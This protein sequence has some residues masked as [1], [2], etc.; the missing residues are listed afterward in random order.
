L[1]LSDLKLDNFK[2]NLNFFE[3]NLYLDIIF[4][5]P[6][7]SLSSKNYSYQM[8]IY[9][10]IFKEEDF[11]NQK[12]FNLIDFGSTSSL[13]FVSFSGEKLNFSFSLTKCP[14]SSN[15]Y[16]FA[17][18]L[19]DLLDQ[20]NFS[21]PVISSITFPEN[22][23]ESTGDISQSSKIYQRVL[24][25]EIRILEGT[26]TGEYLEIYN[27]NNFTVNLNGFRIERITKSGKNYTF[28]SKSNFS[29]IILPPFSYLLI[30]NS[31]TDLDIKNKADIIYPSSY[32]LAKNNALRIV[33]KDNNLIDEVCW[34]QV[35]GF[36]NCLNNPTSNNLS[37]Q[38]KKTAFSSF[39]NI[40]SEFLNKNGE[41][42]Y[43][44][45][46]YDTDISFFDFIQAELE[47]ENSKVTKPTLKEILPLDISLLED[48]KVI[49]KW[50]SPAFYEKDLFYLLKVSIANGFDNLNTSTLNFID[51]S[52]NI[53][54]PSFEILSFQ[55]VKFNLDFQT[56]NLDTNF[57]DRLLIFKLS[58][59]NK[60]NIPDEKFFILDS[61][62]QLNKF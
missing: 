3:D 27:P 44:G 51:L 14:T 39:E 22:F 49:L 16:F 20:E 46:A 26:S 13:P 41:K 61:N 36:S 62:W 34:G 37:F 40:K 9:S 25:S 28:I 19:K 8:L 59:E 38:R 35:S 58:L 33:D 11:K 48:N 15:T 56:L 1:D 23:C 24:F 32:D 18:F 60:D 12:G 53:N 4:S 47:P 55:E 52:Q 10:D 45:N 29:D 50:F 5:E 43:L 2:L 57:N 7:F 17:L 31:S 21:L 42:L 30:L 6:N 54:L